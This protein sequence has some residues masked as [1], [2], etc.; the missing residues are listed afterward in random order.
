MKNLI[1]LSEN[2]IRIQAMENSEGNGS[3]F[4][5][6]FEQNLYGVTAKHIFENKTT[7]KAKIFVPSRE[8]VE[9]SIIDPKC[10]TE[11]DVMVFKVGDDFPINNLNGLQYCVPDYYCY[12]SDVYCLGFPYNVSFD[13]STNG[14]KEIP[15]IKKGVINAISDNF[16]VDKMLA[17]G[18]S[19]GPII[20]ENKVIG[21][22]SDGSYLHLFDTTTKRMAENYNYLAPD[23]FALC[24]NIKEAISL[25]NSCKAKSS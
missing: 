22:I 6:N 7:D 24:V 23:E 16:L 2:V 12:G 18:F 8:W 20:M 13:V 17:V 25:L 19:G 1:D 14:N 10:S 9:F 11:K 3:A 5:I 21:I 15:S 4:F